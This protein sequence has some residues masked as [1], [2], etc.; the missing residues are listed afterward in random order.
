[1]IRVGLLQ[2]CCI[3]VT[4]SAPTRSDL[5][6]HAHQLREVKPRF[7]QSKVITPFFYP[8]SCITDTTYPGDGPRNMKH[9]PDVSFHAFFYRIPDLV[10]C[11]YFLFE[12]IV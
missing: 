11:Y 8:L 1:M 2:E 7:F 5:F 9:V 3:N 12:G 6:L 10:R 4:E